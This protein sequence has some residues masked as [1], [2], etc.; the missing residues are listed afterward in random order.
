M[1]TAFIILPMTPLSVLIFSAGLGAVWLASVPLTSGLIGYIYRLRYMGTLFGIIFFSHQ[2]GGF[3]GVWLD[4][5][6]YDVSGIYEFG[7]WLGIAI[8]AFSAFIHLPI[9]ERPGRAAQP[10]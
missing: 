6:L 1:G 4:G 10:A 7:W 3:M 2:I 5:R 9:R 8:C